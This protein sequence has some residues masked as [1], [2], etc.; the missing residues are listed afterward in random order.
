MP[1][2]ASV[3]PVCPVGVFKDSGCLNF[4]GFFVSPPNKNNCFL[5]GTFG[6]STGIQL[7]PFR[8]VTHEGHINPR[9][10]RNT[11]SLIGLREIWKNIFSLGLLGF[12]KNLFFEKF[13]PI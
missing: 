4:P 10:F 5:L 6:K 2:V 13:S 8:N 12:E 9:G 3:C 1:C 11:G 7:W